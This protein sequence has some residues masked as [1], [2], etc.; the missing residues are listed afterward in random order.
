MQIKKI[1][2]IEIIL[3]Q[4]SAF[5]VDSN[6]N[7]DVRFQNLNGNDIVKETFQIDI[8]TGELFLFTNNHLDREI[9]ERKYAITI[10]YTDF[11]E[12]S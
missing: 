7:G 11:D 10:F 3:L 5:D 12:K 4:V 2:L 1:F 6:Q 9:N 8:N